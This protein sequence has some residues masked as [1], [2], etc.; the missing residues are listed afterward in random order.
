MS[1]NNNTQKIVGLGLFTAIVIVLQLMGSFIKFGTFSISLVLV[2]VVIG[3]ALY[4][5]GA[6]AWLG[7][8]FGVVVLLSGDAAAF[9]GV[10]ALGTILTVLV[11]GTL[12]GLL[13][14]LVY[15]ALE[16]KNRTLAVA[17]AAV[18][19]PVVNTGVFLI[20]CL[21][22]FMETIGG[23]ADAMGFGANVG[24]YMIVGLV[25]ANFIFE[26]LF[27][28][29]FLSTI[30]SL[31]VQGTTVSGMANLLGLAYEERESAFN[32]EMH[33][34]MKSA[35]TEVEVNE[36]LLASGHPLKDITLPENTLVMMV[37]RDGEYFVPQG[38][39]ELKLGDKL[40]VISDRSE[41]LAST[42]KDMGID[43]VMKLG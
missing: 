40:L 24:Q 14:G 41:E 11:K 17:V 13:S 33:E 5:A 18:V 6:G 15:K 26:L 1:K 32:V 35:L 38:K 31:L 42:Y 9:L 34:E 37:C 27:N 23:W 10:N 3:A 8:V 28:V 21:L 36:N 20:G 7:F 30:I 39:T 43:D 12:A 2:P 29:V 22:F 25:G 19:C 4:G 16:N